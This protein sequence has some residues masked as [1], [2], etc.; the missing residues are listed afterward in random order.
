[1]GDIHDRDIVTVMLR[2]RRVSI[3]LMQ[4]REFSSPRV[5]LVRVGSQFATRSGDECVWY[6]RNRKRY[7]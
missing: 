4:T 2:K 1:L 3:H 6:Q 7:N 5:L